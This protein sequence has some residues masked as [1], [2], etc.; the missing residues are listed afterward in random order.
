MFMSKYLLITTVFLGLT[1]HIHAQ[2]NAEDA[3]SPWV[4]ETQKQE[5]RRSLN[6]NQMKLS[7][8]D[9]K[10]DPWQ[11]NTRPT[12]ICLTPLYGSDVPAPYYQQDPSCTYNMDLMILAL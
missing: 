5:R 9:P 6:L 11:K 3:S 8:F 10:S 4:P 12:K 7:I 1:Y 2:A